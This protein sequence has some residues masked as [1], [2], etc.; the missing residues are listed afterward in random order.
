MTLGS[1]A[2]KVATE[3][4]PRRFKRIF[5]CVCVAVGGKSSSALVSGKVS[6]D[7]ISR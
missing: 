4:I 7:K 3:L 1:D 6:V 2:P 5:W